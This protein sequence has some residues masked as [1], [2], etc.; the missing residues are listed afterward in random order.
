MQKTIFLMKKLEIFYKQVSKTVVIVVNRWRDNSNKHMPINS[1]SKSFEVSQ[2][3]FSGMH[4]PPY[5]PYLIPGDCIYVL[6]KSSNHA[7]RA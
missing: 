5:L 4:W 2:I 7:G 1:A 6:P 3:S